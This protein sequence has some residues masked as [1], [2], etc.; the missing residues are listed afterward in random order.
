MD[1]TQLQK[2]PGKALK[3]ETVQLFELVQSVWQILEP[4]AKRKQASL[5]YEGDDLLTIRADRSRLIQ[6]FLN[7][8]DNAIKHN[9][10][11]KNIV[12]RIQ[13][14]TPAE[15]NSMQQIKIDVIDSGLGFKASD[16]PHIF[17]RLYRGDKSRTREQQNPFAEGSGLGLAIVEQI[18][19][20]HNGTIT[21]KNYPRK[22]GA[23]LEITLPIDKTA[24]LSGKS[25]E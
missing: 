10:C 21:A 1:L 16:L 6:V 22:G 15:P 18:I 17:E 2:Q 5:T 13:P 7:L 4:I 25:S 9:P 20:A 3:Y 11:S 24:N 8:L 12:V 23:W 14:H 19:R